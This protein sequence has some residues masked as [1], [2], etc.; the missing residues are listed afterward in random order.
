MLPMLNTNAGS[1]NSTNAY[2]NA[3]NM[4]ILA[5]TSYTDAQYQ[6][7]AMTMLQTNN[8]NSMT[9]HQFVASLTV[10]ICWYHL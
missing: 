6:Y 10:S 9:H 8:L 4:L 7:W 1:D 3:S 5:N 2:A